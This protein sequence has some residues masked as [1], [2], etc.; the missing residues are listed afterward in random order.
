ML[1]ISGVK[2]SRAT[3]LLITVDSL[4][5]ALGLMITTA[6]RLVASGADQERLYSGQIVAR[7]ALVVFVWD[8]A[9][10]YNDLYDLRVSKR[11]SVMF[12]QLLQAL[13]VA[14][15]AL[16]VLYYAEPRLSLGRDNTAMAV[17]AV[18]VLLLGGRLLLD[19]LGL[20]SHY[21]DR[22]L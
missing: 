15:L 5:V 4:A 8:V 7:L 19:H 18:L 3:L 21:L 20:L 10:Y 14:C 2:I 13:G 11:R 6:I 16:A 12:N 9:L 22:V 17:P 1:K